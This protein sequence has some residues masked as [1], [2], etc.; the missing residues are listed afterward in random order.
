MATDSCRN[1]TPIT[2]AENVENENPALYAS[3]IVAGENIK[4]LL[5]ETAA[6]PEIQPPTLCMLNL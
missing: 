3:L 5:P 6:F 4:Y 2:A 1:V